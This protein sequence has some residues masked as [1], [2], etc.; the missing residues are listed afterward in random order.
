LAAASALEK[1]RTAMTTC[2]SPPAARAL[3]AARPKPD[4]A[5]VMTTVFF[6]EVLGSAVTAAGGWAR[7]AGGAAVAVAGAGAGPRRAG[8][9][10]GRTA[11]PAT[12]VHARTCERFVA[13]AR[14]AGEE[15][16][17]SMV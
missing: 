14:A 3:A 17:A 2:Q 10:A 11:P 5:P 6:W 9:E 1:S 7:R 15:R 8:A 16:A 13:V 4:E 12:D